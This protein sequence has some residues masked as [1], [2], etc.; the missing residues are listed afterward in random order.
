[1]ILLLW[2]PW[3]RGFHRTRTG[4][5]IRARFAHPHAD[6]PG[7]LILGHMDT[8]HPLGTL[9]NLPFQPDGNRCYGPA[10]VI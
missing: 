5:C 4:D 10:Y 2:E 8:V 1:M 9:N 7:I 3:L 6:R